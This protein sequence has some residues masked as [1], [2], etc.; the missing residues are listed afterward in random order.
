MMARHS[1]GERGER[2]FA[3]MKD[4]GRR[5]RALEPDLV[6]IISSDH[7]YNYSLDMQPPFALAT[8]DAFV[9]F[10][11]MDLPKETFPGHPEFADGLMHAASEGDF[12]LTRLTSYRPD[13]GVVLPYLMMSPQRTLPAV[14]LIINTSC[15]PVPPL[16]RAWQL[17]EILSAFCRDKRPAQE[18]LVVVGTGGLS[19][20]LGVPEMGKTNPHFDHAVMDAIL[21][22]QGKDLTAWSQEKVR[23]EGGNGGQEI[24][25]WVCMA[26]ALGPS[27]KGERLYYEDVPEWVTGM[28]GIELR[29]VAA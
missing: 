2:V 4:I 5:I 9:P 14:P 1:A 15:N 11:D 19:H 12:D 3:G 16:R 29:P 27:V 21:S 28:G 10:G 26:G 13:H 7:M 6:L 23:A 17:G 25:N 20:W 24:L 18:R 22:G 8:D